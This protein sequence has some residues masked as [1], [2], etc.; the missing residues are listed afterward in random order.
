MFLYHFI[1][2][3]KV[4]AHK[5]AKISSKEEIEFALTFGDGKRATYVGANASF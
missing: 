4:K 3:K 5:E 2:I 1:E